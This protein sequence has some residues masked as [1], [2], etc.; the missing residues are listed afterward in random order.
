[1]TDTRLQDL[2]TPP[3]NLE[4]E[5]AVLGSVLIDPESFFDVAQFLKTDDFHTV[6]HQW[7]WDVF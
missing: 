7:I 4:A 5:E 6:K 1:M 3:Y 2:N